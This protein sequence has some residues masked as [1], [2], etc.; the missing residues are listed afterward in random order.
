MQYI[1]SRVSTDKQETQN[2]LSQLKDLFPG[3]AVFE[4]V[5]SGAKARPVLQ[6]LLGILKKGDVLVVAALDRLGRRTSEVLG[7]IEDLE[8]RE[9]VLKSIREGVDYSTIAGRLVTQILVSVAEME[10]RLI[11]ERTRLAL[12]AKRRAGVRLGCPAKYSAL[13]VQR[14]QEL[15]AQGRTVRDVA[16][17]TG[18]SASRV[19]Q[20]CRMV[21]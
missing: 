19:S 11:G 13:T 7:L 8:R 2:Q 20:L 3:A 9:V 21:G 1:Y 6:T 17:A 14:V 15:R 12:D 16:N 10:R 4:E 5:A 18:M